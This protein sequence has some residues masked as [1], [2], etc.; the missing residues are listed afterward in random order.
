MTQTRS[1][2]DGEPPVAKAPPP[3]P[4]MSF[5]DH[6]EELRRRILKG[7][8][9][10]AVGVVIAGIFSDF[11]IDVVLL[12]PAKKDFFIYGWL[13][14]DA[15]DLTFQNRNLP[16]QFFTYWGLL[17]SVGLVIG[18]PAFFYQMWM[19]I[20]PALETTERRNVHGI[21]FFISAMFAIGILFGYLVLTPFALQFFANFTISDFVR[22]DFDINAYFTSVA[23]W[24]LAC[25]FIFQIPFISYI[26]SKVGLLTPD[27]LRK[28]RRFAI[29]TCFI[30]G[31]ILTPPD[32]VSQFLVAIPL[33]LLYQ[34]GIW[35]STVVNRRRDKILR[36]DAA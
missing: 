17:F 22:N 14:I 34:I 15:V 28:Y 1:V 4:E 21:V 33:L 11:F 10:L 18:S 7:L 5:L 25:G 3:P 8:I 9:G 2:M 20:E 12:G 29:V 23:M 32:P 36:G 13:G 26:L 31:G 27:F 19:F 6:L 30:L 16:G 24:A 35:I